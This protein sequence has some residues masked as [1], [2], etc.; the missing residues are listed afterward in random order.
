MDAINKGWFS[1]L[2]SLWPGQSFSLEVEEVLHKSKSD[3]QDVLVFKSKNYGNVLVLDG[4]IQVTERDE[5]SYHE[6]ITHIPLFAHPNPKDIL[7]VGGGDGGCVREALKHKGV[8]SITLCEIDKAVI[9]VSK[10]YLP[11]VSC[12]YSS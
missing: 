1:E 3:F 10:Q 8:Q 5:F 11:N 7:I 12:G 6:M 2:G 4:A 9:D